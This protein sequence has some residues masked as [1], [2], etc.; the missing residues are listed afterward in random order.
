LSRVDLWQLKQLWEMFDIK[1]DDPRKEVLHNM[2]QFN[3]ALACL[4]NLFE[5]VWPKEYTGG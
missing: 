4:G 3:Q 5:H 1:Q 2:G